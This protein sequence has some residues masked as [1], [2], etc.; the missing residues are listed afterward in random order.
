MIRGIRNLVSCGFSLEDAVKTASSNPA[1]V[2]RYT[3]QGAIIP[4]HLG[5]LTVFDNDFQVRLVIVGGEI[6]KNLFAGV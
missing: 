4:G 6:K 3:R 5:D 2:M 1:A